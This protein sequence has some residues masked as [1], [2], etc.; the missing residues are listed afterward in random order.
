M[1]RHLTP[2]ECEMAAALLRKAADSFSNHGCNDYDVTA[3]HGLTPLEC[4]DLHVE[5]ARRNGDTEEEIA[6]MYDGPV[7]H[8][9]WLMLHLAA[10]LK[11]SAG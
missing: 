2:Q 4:R 5:M 10:R 6:E 9:W 7:F 1:A 11:E 3:E 8:D